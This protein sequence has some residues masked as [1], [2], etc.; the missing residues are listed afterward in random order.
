MTEIAGLDF[1]CPVL[2]V[3]L[4]N[5]SKSENQTRIDTVILASLAFRRRRASFGLAEEEKRGVGRKW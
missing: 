4:E 2:G 5:N 3:E 1:L